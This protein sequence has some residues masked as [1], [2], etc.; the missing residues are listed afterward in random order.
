[1]VTRSAWEGGGSGNRVVRGGSFSSL[2]DENL[3]LTTTHRWV[4]APAQR[5]GF[6]G[7]RC[8]R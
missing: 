6:V 1:M 5:S 2:G 7:V 4:E 3:P 8:A